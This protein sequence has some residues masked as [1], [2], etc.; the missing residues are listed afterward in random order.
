MVTAQLFSDLAGR[1]SRTS[2]QTFRCKPG[3]EIAAHKARAEV[4]ACKAR[5]EATARNTE[6]AA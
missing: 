5:A 3:A 1:D 2:W 6:V 4:V